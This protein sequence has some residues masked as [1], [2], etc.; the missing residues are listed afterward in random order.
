M[1]PEP[2]SGKVRF[3]LIEK[4][5]EGIR[6]GKG[7]L[8]GNQ[9]WGREKKRMFKFARFVSAPTM[10]W[11]SLCLSIILHFFPEH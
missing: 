1:T 6:G 3:N 11:V 4:Q 9:G 2:F 8:K 10:L 5:E 7:H